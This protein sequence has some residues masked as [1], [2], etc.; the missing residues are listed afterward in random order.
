MQQ[1]KK[2]A[3]LAVIKKGILL[4]NN[5]LPQEFSSYWVTAK[6]LWRRLLHVGV[7]KSLTLELVHNA[8]WRNNKNQS[9]LKV[10]VYNGT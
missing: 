9:Y 2:A 4:I 5:D 1:E 7:R 10:W 8:L 3:L 6:D